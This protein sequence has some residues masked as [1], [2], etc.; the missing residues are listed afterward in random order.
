M[1]TSSIEQAEALWARL[2]RALRPL[3]ELDGATADA[4]QWILAD[5]RPR[6]IEM[7]LRAATAGPIAG[8]IQLVRLERELYEARFGVSVATPERH[9][10]W[11]A[12]TPGGAMTRQ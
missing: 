2:E 10:E 8:L 5:L 3:L 9:A 1:T 12:A 11:A 7:E 4:I 6:V